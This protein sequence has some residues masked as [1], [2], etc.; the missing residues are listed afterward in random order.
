MRLISASLTKDQIRQS[1][2]NVQAGLP[3]VKD[4]TRRRGWWNVKVGEELQIC[5]KVMG[6][7]HG[8]P[9]VR[10]CV[11]RVVSVRRE[12]LRRLTKGANYGREEVRREGFPDMTAAEFVEFFCRTHRGCRP[13]TEINRIEFEYKT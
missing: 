2:A 9:L 13:E 1:V 4:V 8:E 7:I 6:R 3:P 10:I 11:V 12:S 5:E